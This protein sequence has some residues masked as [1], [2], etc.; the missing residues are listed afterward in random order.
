M[1]LKLQF[2]CTFLA[3]GLV[4][5]MQSF[6]AS[7][8]VPEGIPP[9][10]VKTHFTVALQY[11]ELAQ[12]NKAKADNWEFMADYYEKFPKEYNDKSM[13]LKEHIAHLRAIAADFRKVEEQDR[14]LAKKHHYLARHGLG[15]P[16]M[17]LESSESAKESPN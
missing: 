13:S 8:D 5:A 9:G 17:S 12:I 3:L 2:T 7:A 6:A 15:P 11:E 14:A 16:T 4:V 1:M 10:G